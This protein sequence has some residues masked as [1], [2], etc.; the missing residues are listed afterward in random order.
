M[1]EGE[2][3]M[4]VQQARA[5]NRQQKILRAAASVISRRG[6]QEAGIEEIAREAETS[7]GGVY[8]HFP[9]KESILL[10]LLDH[11]SGLVRGKVEQAIAAESD[12]VAKADAALRALLRTLAKHRS[13][14]RVFA[15]E[16]A[17]AGPKF[18]ARVAEIQDEFVALVR[19]QLDAAVATGAIVPMDTTIVAQAWMGALDAV[20]LRYVTSRPGPGRRSLDKIHETLRQTLLRSIGAQVPGAALSVVGG[21]RRP[22]DSIEAKGLE[23]R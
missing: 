15:V 1:I 18:N 16:A 7:K 17:G 9:G 13:L 2:F 23:R 12:P 6:Y 11:T 19:E 3:P 4:P 8:F 10:A 22:T 14:A 20:L 5:R 21:S